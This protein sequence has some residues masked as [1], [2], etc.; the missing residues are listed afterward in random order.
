MALTVPVPSPAWPAVALA[1][2]VSACVR[3]CDPWEAR[4]AARAGARCPDLHPCPPSHAA[5]SLG[6]RGH[7]IASSLRRP[8]LPELCTPLSRLT[9]RHQQYQ[10]YTRFDSPFSSS[11]R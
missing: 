4:V 8:C 5:F 11:N 3:A 2:H 9:L 10:Q 7:D 1:G 6:P